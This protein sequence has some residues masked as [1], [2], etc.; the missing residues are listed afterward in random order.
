[1]GFD[2]GKVQTGHYEELA[3]LLSLEGM[4]L[5]LAKVQLSGVSGWADVGTGV[6]CEW[7]PS[8]WDSQ[9]HRYAQSVQPIRTASNV[10][11]GMFDLIYLP[12]CDE[13]SILRGAQRGTA[14]C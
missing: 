12:L 4:E 8:I 6:L 5:E 1:M 14:S 10:A 11:S 7:A 13:R 9:I 3:N 2:I